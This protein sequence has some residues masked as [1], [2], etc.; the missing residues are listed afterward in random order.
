MDEKRIE[1]LETQDD[2]HAGLMAVV[3]R[4]GAMAEGLRVSRYSS[5]TV[6]VN[7]ETGSSLLVVGPDRVRAIGSNGETLS[8]ETDH[9][10]AIDALVLHEVRR[11]LRL[12]RG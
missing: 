5:E 8:P 2:L 12:A 11:A 3:E 10:T 7:D 4:L 1:A 6:V 9:A